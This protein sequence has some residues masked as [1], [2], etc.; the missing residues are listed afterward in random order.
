MKHYFL[1]FFR[2]LFKKKPQKPLIYISGKITGDE[3]IAFEIFE[4]TE[5]W[6]S[7]GGYQ[8]INPMK[9]PHRHDRTW[10]SYMREDIEALVKCDSIYMLHG[11]QKSKGACIEHS[12][13]ESIGLNIRYQSHL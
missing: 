6:L 5:I 2:F 13:A 10:Q 1:S 3:D 12:L 4:R 11:W 9:L 7:Q 8:V